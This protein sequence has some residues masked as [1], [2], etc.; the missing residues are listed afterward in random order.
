MILLY[1]SIPFM[2]VVVSIAL[3]PLLW[4]MK[5]ERLQQASAGPTMIRMTPKR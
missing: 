5:H 3:A 2:L 1:L 4:A